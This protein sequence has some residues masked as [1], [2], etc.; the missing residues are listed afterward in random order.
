MAREDMAALYDRD[1]LEWTARNAELLRQGCVAEADLEH[2]AEEIADLGKRD[3]H[4]AQNRLVIL[5]THLLQ[6]SL[7]PQRRYRE[8]GA[9]SWLATIREQRRQLANLFEHSPSLKN[10]AEQ[11]LRDA[12]RY[13]VKEASAQ[14]GIPIPQFPNEC[15]FGFDQILEDE[16]LPE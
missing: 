14:T 3:K 13:A 15:P 5:V 11:T 7:Q 4:E 1:F 16:F 12:H 8:S 6:W 9:S 10:Y 2:V